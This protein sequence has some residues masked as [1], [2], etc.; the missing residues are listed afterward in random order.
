MTAQ[1]KPVSPFPPVAKKQAVMTYI[2][3]DL[4]TVEHNTP[5]PA[6]RR[7]VGKYDAVF[8]KLRFGSCVACEPDEMNKVANALRKWLEREEKP[9]KVVSVKRDKDGRARVWLIEGGKK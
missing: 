4:L 7:V 8:S 9:G 2:D 5:L 1:R 3:P 6:A